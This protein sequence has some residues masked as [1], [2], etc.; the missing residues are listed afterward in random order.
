MPPM[1]TEEKNK[2]WPS[3]L[4]GET[5]INQVITEIVINLGR[6][7]PWSYKVGDLA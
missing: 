7:G 4:V 3:S 1:A 2:F 5:G 6:G